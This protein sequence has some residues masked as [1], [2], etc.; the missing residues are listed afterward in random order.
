M[1]LSFNKYLAITVTLLCFSN[2]SFASGVLDCA[3]AN[4]DNGSYDYGDAT[5]SGNATVSNGSKYGQACHDT[6]RWQQL[7]WTGDGALEGDSG[8]RSDDANKNGGW[9]AETTQNDVDAGDNGVKW[10]VQNSDGT[11]PINF[12]REELTAGA[13]VEFFFIVKR[14]NEG[15]HKFDQLKAWNDWNGNGIFEDNEA[16]IDEK[17]YKN[18]DRNGNLLANTS[19]TNSD[20]PT[21]NNADVWRKYYTVMQVPIDAVVG[22]TWMRARIICENS[23]TTDDRDNN[24]FLS[25]GYYH[26]GEVEDY[27]VAINA[28][29]PTPVPEPTTLLVFGSALIGLVLSR[30][31][32]K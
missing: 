20:L 16:I 3:T 9:N 5:E 21:N 13:N 32:A 8:D 15:N 7:G 31:K 18:H 14:S 12:S 24:I 10:K 1:R 11:W 22:E 19:N 4:K 2:V 26:Q 28:R 25:T 23:L 29:P 27:K 6:N 30:R 17:W